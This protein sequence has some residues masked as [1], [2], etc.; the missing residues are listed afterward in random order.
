MQSL[1]LI[2]SDGNSCIVTLNNTS[3][4]SITFVF[5]VLFSIYHTDSIF[6]SNTTLTVSECYNIN[7]Y[8]HVSCT[9]Y[10]LLILNLGLDQNKLKYDLPRIAERKLLLTQIEDHIHRIIN[11]FCNDRPA[12][13]EYL[14]Y[15]NCRDLKQNYYGTGLL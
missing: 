3:F 9:F 8:F 15:R 11:L 1:Y 6:M 10:V 14:T 12:T 2:S 4:I 7:I 13:N 5:C